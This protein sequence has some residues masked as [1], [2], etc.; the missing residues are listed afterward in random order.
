MKERVMN[1][2][3]RLAGK[4]ALI[5]GTTAFKEGPSH[6]QRRPVGASDT[7]QGTEKSLREQYLEECRRLGPALT[8]AQ[9]DELRALGHQLLNPRSD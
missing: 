2:P 9:L 3:A 4:R 7:D 1:E 5:T 8:D 6:D